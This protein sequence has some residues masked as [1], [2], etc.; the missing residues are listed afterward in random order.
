MQAI[1]PHG[2]YTG[3]AISITSSVAGVAVLP[4]TA[5]V[6][7]GA[8]LQLGATVTGAGSF[9]TAVTW[10]TTAGT[11][12]SSGL[13]TAPAA[14]GSPQTVT[15]TA[16][17]VQDGTKHGACTVTVPALTI[18]TVT[19]VVVSP[20]V[21]SVLGLGTATFTAVVNGSGSP[22]Q[23]VTWTASSGSIT[24]GGVFTAPAYTGSVQTITVTATSVQDNTKS[25]TAT[26]TV[27]ASAPTS[28]ARMGIN[29]EAIAFF[30]KNDAFNNMMTQAGSNGGAIW[31]NNQYADNHNSQGYPTDTQNAIVLRQSMDVSVGGVYKVQYDTT[32]SG[33]T[34]SIDNCTM[35]NRAETAISG[36][37]RVNYDATY[38]GGTMTFRYANAPGGI[39]NIFV[40]HPGQAQSDL[41]S[42]TFKARISRFASI[43]FYQAEGEEGEG[44]NT[45]NDKFWSNRRPGNFMT[46]CNYSAAQN[47]IPYEAMIQMCNDLNLDCYVN[48]PYLTLADTGFSGEGRGDGIAST[49]DYVTKMAQVFKYGSDGVNPYTS[50]QANPVFPP[51]K[52]GLNVYVEFG[53]ELWNGGN[54]IY[55]RDKDWNTA[56]AARE[57]ALPGN[58]YNYITNNSPFSQ[59]RSRIGR[60][61]MQMSD[62]WRAVWGSGAMGTTV[63]ILSSGAVG[64]AFSEDVLAY[65]QQQAS[66]AGRSVA[67]YVYGFCVGPYYN[68]GGNLRGQR[69]QQRRNRQQRSGHHPR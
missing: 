67:S 53:N 12:S 52:P 26:V 35:S 3:A 14:T 27:P 10:T 7:G 25:G 55:G 38:N 18:A 17:S 8:T 60:I 30:T 40:T 24:S 58:P 46:Y 21:V 4:L 13:F 69:R 57:A 34:C 59:Q 11:V 2:S 63:R 20:L 39:R 44:V 48:V 41:L 62:I 31:G 47:G 33:S 19:S 9:S 28:T 56:A 61:V 36:G 29:I 32:N 1:L 22:V 6:V 23:S 66:A 65:I 54:A 49:S 68:E 42:N 64:D 15:V 43:R 5:S 37:Y 16:T 50:T 51:L 45:N